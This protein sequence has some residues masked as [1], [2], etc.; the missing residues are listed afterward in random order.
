M[1]TDYLHSLLHLQVKFFCPL[2]LLFVKPNPILLGKLPMEK[3][4]KEV[5]HSKMKLG[6]HAPKQDARTFQLSAYLQHDELPATP[7]DWNWGHKVGADKWGMMCNR[8]VENCT[9]AAA[10]HFIMTWTSN[11]GKL[12]KPSDKAILKTYSALTGYD[13]KTGANNTGACAI[14]V[15]K[16]WRKN[17]IEG[18]KIFAFAEVDHRKHQLVKQTVFLFG[19]CYVGL[20]L[21]KSSVKQTVWDVPPV[22]VNGE[23]AFNSWGGH[24]VLITGYNTE[25]LRAITWGKEK[26]MTWDFWDA[27]T[28]ES[29]AVFS[30]DFIKN[31]QNP[32]GVNV[33][34]LK[35]DLE[36]LKDKS[37]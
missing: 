28:D 35:L 8:K 5:D 6:K 31:N 13:P 30:E 18:H 27:Y 33:N 1:H 22:G 32:A 4:H 23:G 24:A 16:H 17:D 25:G 34:A 3:I 19:G 10:G 11:T 2:V 12:F 26:F 20:G 37:N 14:D 36:K 7:D 29:F 21:P 9:C 15:L